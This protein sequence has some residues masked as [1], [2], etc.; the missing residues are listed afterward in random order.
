MSEKRKEA[1]KRI[2]EVRSEEA[3]ELN[4]TGLGLTALPTEIAAL[5]Q[6]QTLS[7]SS[8]QLTV[9]PTEIAAL[10]LLQELKLNHN[11]LTVVPP[12]IA[13]LAQLQTLELNDNQ[14]KA[15]PPDIAALAQLQTLKLNDN[16]LTVLPPEIGRLDKLN[17]LSID[18]NPL[19]PI[20]HRIQARG[21][22]DLRTYLRSLEGAEPL[23]EAKLLFVGEGATMDRTALRCSNPGPE[24]FGS[25][26]VR[27]GPT[28]S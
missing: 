24:N 2:A 25:R 1:A 12:E 3:I 15:L 13:A 19:P 17:D 20:L 14:L 18:N 21:L 11:Q 9:L 8:N 4:L 7:L 10:T 28:T 23:Y 27:S 6:L 16:Q 22:D 5:T 26:C